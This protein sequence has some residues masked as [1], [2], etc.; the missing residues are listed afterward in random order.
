[1]RR[2]STPDRV[3]YGADT[4]V[5]WLLPYDDPATGK[6]FDFEW[7]AAINNRN[8]DGTDCPFLSNRVVWEVFNDLASVYPN[9]SAE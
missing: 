8:D 7:K 2:L 5:W 4:I 9:I 1:M 6:H 3:S